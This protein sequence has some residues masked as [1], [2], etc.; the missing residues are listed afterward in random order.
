MIQISKF[1][2]KKYKHLKITS[3]TKENSKNTTKLNQITL[4]GIKSENEPEKNKHK[5]EMKPDETD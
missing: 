3:N 2:G 4:L 1:A 5:L